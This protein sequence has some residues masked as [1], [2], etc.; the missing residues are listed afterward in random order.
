MLKRVLNA[1][2]HEVLPGKTPFDVAPILSK[3]LGTQVFLKREDT[4]PVFSF[5]LRGAYNR[6]AHLD[7]EEAGRGVLAVSAGNHAQGVAY[8]AQRLGL[9]AR[10]VMP[11]TTPS[12]KVRAVRS[13]GAEVDLFGDNFADASI[14]LE[15]LAAETGMTVIPPYDDLDVIAGQGT[16]GLEIINQAPRDLGSVFIPV[17]GGGL[18]AGIAAVIKGIRPEIRLIG[19]EPEDADAMT[20]SLAAGERVSL[21]HVG[22]FADGVA[23]KQ[24]GEL[25]FDLCQRYLDDCITVS[26]D[27]IC[28]G[29]KD[30]FENT[31]CVLEPAGA[32]AIAGVKRAV[33]D[34]WLPEGPTAA[35]TSGANMNFNRLRYVSERAEAGEEG[36]ALLAVTIPERP[37]AFLEFCKTIGKRGVTEF[38]YRLAQR[39]EAH[40]FVGLQTAGAE[41]AN[42]VV[43]L[44]QERGY[45][46]VDL[47]HD[48]LAKTHIRHMV[49]GRATDVADEVL[50]R[51]EFPER[52]GALMEFLSR[53]G[54]QWNISLFHYRSQGGAYGRILCGL[55]VPVDERR[56]LGQ[57]LQEIGFPHFEESDS[58]AARFFL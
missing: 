1:R 14:R 31:R 42:S 3:R 7:R 8:A 21:D 57:V 47:S 26:I 48:D 12:I 37:G 9:R 23:V 45:A 58:P 35:I 19:V 49:G 52:P 40:I 20:Q 27:E 33:R 32:L 25:T 50:F 53:L 41:E 56:A 43:D 38:N 34:G 29:I 30:G 24:V 11:G 46:V 16:V 44:L 28:A 18:A 10:I 5:K 6:M 39:E 51:F 36:E 22:I 13:L 17:G 15:E 54:Q 4:T 2:V 55:E